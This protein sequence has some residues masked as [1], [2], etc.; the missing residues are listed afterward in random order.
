VAGGPDYGI[1]LTLEGGPSKLSLGRGFPE[2]RSTRPERHQGRTLL[3]VAVGAN[4]ADAYVVGRC[5]GQ[6]GR[7][8]DPR[9][10]LKQ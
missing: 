5:Q 6:D 9:Y 2:A 3:T 4:M 1:D 10:K 8:R 7:E